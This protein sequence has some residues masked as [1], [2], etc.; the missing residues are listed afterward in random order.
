M[1]N[2]RSKKLANA[3]EPIVYS[4]DINPN[5]KQYSFGISQNSKQKNIEQNLLILRKTP[6]WKSPLSQEVSCYQDQNNTYICN[7]GDSLLGKKILIYCNTNQSS[8]YYFHKNYNNENKI[9][10]YEIK[11]SSNEIVYFPT[12]K[13]DYNIYLES[14]SE[15]DDEEKIFNNGIKYSS[16]DLDIVPFV[17]QGMVFNT[18]TSF[19]S[20]DDIY[21]TLEDEKGDL[22]LLCSDYECTI[23]KDNKLNV[24]CIVQLDN[25]KIENVYYTEKSD[26]DKVRFIISDYG[27]HISHSTS[28]NNGQFENNLGFMLSP[29]AKE[30]SKKNVSVRFS[31]DNKNY[32][33]NLTTNF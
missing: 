23:P 10:E 33:T 1:N 26:Y 17:L 25:D 11:D 4:F 28:T 31:I 22:I 18:N 7:F 27:R 6:F 8:D 16:I 30:E 5:C 21:L 19:S 2:L 14:S 20:S 24:T 9:L 3:A 29:E 12:I 13:I 15:K 32:S